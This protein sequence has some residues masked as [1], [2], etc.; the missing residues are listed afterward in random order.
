MQ[1]TPKQ[2]AALVASRGYLRIVDHKNYNP[3]L[4]EFLTSAA[5]VGDFDSGHWTKYASAAFVRLPGLGTP[6]G[7]GVVAFADHTAAES[8]VRSRVGAARIH[9]PGQVP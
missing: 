5:W 1:H 3:R 7:T 6:M 9:S 8:A 4:I 2:L